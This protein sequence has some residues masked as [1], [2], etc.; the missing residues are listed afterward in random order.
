M[1]CRSPANLTTFRAFCAIKK[2]KEAF[3]YRCVGERITR[4]GWHFPPSW[5]CILHAD[6]LLCFLRTISRLPAMPNAHIATHVIEKRRWKKTRVERW[7]S[8][9]WWNVLYIMRLRSRADERVGGQFR[10]QHVGRIDNLF[11][12][13]RVDARQ[14]PT[15]LVIQVMPRRPNS[16]SRKALGGGGRYG[17]LSLSCNFP[18]SSTYS[19]YQLIHYHQVVALCITKL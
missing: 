13:G 3:H 2:K 1:R 11:Q 5:S 15:R 7:N 4:L 14:R 19:F 18:F 16:F 8:V 12:L 10:P 17:W 9:Q 6:L